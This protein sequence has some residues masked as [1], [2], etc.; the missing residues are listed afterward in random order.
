MIQ[1]INI[2]E[3]WPSYVNATLMTFKVLHTLI[4]V[5]STFE[6]CLQICINCFI[7]FYLV[8]KTLTFNCDMGD[9]NCFEKNSAWDIKKIIKRH[10]NYPKWMDTFLDN[11]RNLSILILKI[12]NFDRQQPMCFACWFLSMFEVVHIE[13]HLSFFHW[14]ASQ[15]LNNS[16][17]FCGRTPMFQ[18]KLNSYSVCS[19]L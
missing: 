1:P 6:N 16:N 10:W 7:L 2:K 5:F 12:A 3:K 18:E 8:W 11:P 4:C 13:F 19:L 15:N 9:V 14:F 17:S